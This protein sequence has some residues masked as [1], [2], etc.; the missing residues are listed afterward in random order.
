MRIT[1]D[2]DTSPGRDVQETLRVLN[3]QLRAMVEIGRPQFRSRE[4][5]GLAL[6][7]LGLWLPDGS[8]QYQTPI[9]Y[10]REPRGK[11]W[12]RE[13]WQDPARTWELKEGDCEDLS[14][15]Q[16]CE[17]QELDGI[18]AWPRVRAFPPRIL[19]G[20]KP[21]RFWLLHVDVELPFGEL[22]PSRALGMLDGVGKWQ[23]SPG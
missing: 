9:R 17:L 19:R 16:A 13:N 15:Y 18:D 12:V 10:Q 14:I 21:R 6:P 22:D 20:G 4:E 2:L 8:Y 23:S 5:G 3:I 7:P 11:G 1:L